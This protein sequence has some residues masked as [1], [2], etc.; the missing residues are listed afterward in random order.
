M[1]I[2][3]RI[4]TSE[5]LIFCAWTIYSGDHLVW[6]MASGPHFFVQDGKWKPKHER[7]QRTFLYEKERLTILAKL[8]EVPRRNWQNR[9]WKEGILKALSLSVACKSIQ[10]LLARLRRQ[11]TPRKSNPISPICTISKNS[12]PW[13]KT[14]FI[15][16]Q[17]LWVKFAGRVLPFWIVQ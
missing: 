12:I 13:S 7:E 14:S 16:L 11:M 15:G 4:L 17:L 8:P 6:C 2:L 9:I 10:C 3:V 5:E 1:C